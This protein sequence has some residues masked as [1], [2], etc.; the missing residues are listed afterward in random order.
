MS[1]GVCLGLEFYA[2]TM[3]RVDYGDTIPLHTNHYLSCNRDR[4]ADP[5]YMNTKMRYDR[6]LELCQNLEIQ[7]LA[8]MKKILLDGKNDDNAICRRYGDF[9]GYQLGTICSIIMDL[10]ARTMFITPGPPS[11]YDFEVYK[12]D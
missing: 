6:G 9:L 7:D 5:G 3:S 10:P 4:Q 1:R 11:K 12:L 2:D 8:S